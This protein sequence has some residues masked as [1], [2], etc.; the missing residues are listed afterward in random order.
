MYDHVIDED[1]K[2]AIKKRL[3]FSGIRVKGPIEDAL[4]EF[5]A[6]VADECSDD[7]EDVDEDDKSADDPLYEDDHDLA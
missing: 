4:D 6:V 5:L 1:L 2:D 7:D 3:A